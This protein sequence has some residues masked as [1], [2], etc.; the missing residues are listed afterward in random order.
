MVP[1]APSQANGIEMWTRPISP[2]RGDEHSYAVAV[3]SQRTD[4]TPAAVSHSAGRS[5]AAC[6]A[7][8]FEGRGAPVGESTGPVCRI[9]P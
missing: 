7:V 2:S 4:G 5:F 3:L 9:L 1:V 6:R 8:A